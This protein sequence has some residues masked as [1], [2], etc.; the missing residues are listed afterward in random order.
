MKNAYSL[1]HDVDNNVVEQFNAII[2]KMIGGKRV[3]Y[4]LRG[5]YQSRCSAAVVSHNTKKPI[6]IMKKYL[7]CGKSPSSFTK[8][9]EFAKKYKR[10]GLRR[11]LFSKTGKEDGKSYGEQCEKPDL[12]DE[13]LAHEK[14]QFLE[15][16]QKSEDALKDLERKTIDQSNSD[17]WYLERRKRITASNFFDVCTKFGSKSKGNTQKLVEKILYPKDF[18]SPSTDWGR[19]HENLAIKELENKIGKKIEPCGLFVDFNNQFL[20]ATPDGLIGEQ[21]IV[22]IK[23]PYSAKNISA[24]QAIEE[25]KITFWAKTGEINK[26]HRWYYQ[27]QGQLFITKRSYCCFAVWTPHGIQHEVIFKDEPFWEKIKKQ[28]NDFYMDCLLPELVDPRKC[29]NMPLRD[30][31]VKES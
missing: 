23:C 8:K 4:C 20:A 15:R 22:E 19:K 11:K 14:E 26:R 31:I 24:R 5:S 28:L 18:F 6:Y 2:A 10:K 3:N 30:V 9:V 27:I 25:K 1:I 29:R 13:E 17:L 12:N 7:N 21:G 16:L